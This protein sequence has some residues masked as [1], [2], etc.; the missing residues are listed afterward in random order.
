MPSLLQS[1]GDGLI[2]ADGVQKRLL[3]GV[4][5]FA[6]F[7]VT[8]GGFNRPF[9]R[10]QIFFQIVRHFDV[11]SSRPTVERCLNVCK[12]LLI[13]FLVERFI[14]RQTDQVEEQD[15]SRFKITGRRLR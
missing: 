2:E 15:P 6:I 3:P 12:R 4:L 8:V 13:D 11:R 14:R 1:E 5:I 7:Y 10:R 9:K